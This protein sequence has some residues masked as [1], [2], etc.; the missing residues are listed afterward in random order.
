[1]ARDVPSPCCGSFSIDIKESISNNVQEVRTE[2]ESL[3]GVQW[4]RGK[5][6]SALLKFSCHCGSCGLQYGEE[7]DSRAEA[8]YNYDQRCFELWRRNPNGLRAWMKEPP[9]DKDDVIKRQLIQDLIKKRFTDMY[10]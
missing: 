6:A 3:N 8:L 7:A 5:S 2:K 4:K 1:M 9:Q 10:G